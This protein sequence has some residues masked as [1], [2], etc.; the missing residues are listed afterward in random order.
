MPQWLLVQFS[1]HFL[2]SFKNEKEA[3]NV[4]AVVNG[5]FESSKFRVTNQLSLLKLFISI[6]FQ[7]TMG[8]RKNKTRKSSRPPK[9]KK[10]SSNQY[11]AGKV[12]E[13][14]VKDKVKKATVRLNVGAGYRKIVSL[15]QG[16]PQ[17]Q[18]VT[19]PSGSQ[20]NLVQF[21][22]SVFFLM[23]F[24]CLKDIINL[25]G[26]CPY[27]SHG[28]DIN[29]DTSEKL[30][31]SQQLLL[32][33]QSSYC[34][35]KA[36]KYSSPE[37]HRPSTPGRKFQTVNLR[38]VM[39]FREI[40]KGHQALQTFAS[41]MNMPRPMSHSNY[42]SINEVLHGAYETIAESSM[43]NTAKEVR[44][45]LNNDASDNDILDTQVSIDG[46]WQ[47]GGQSSMNGV[48]TA[49][50]SKGKVTDQLVMT[51]HCRACSIWEKKKGTQEYDE[52]LANH[53]CK[54]NHN[55]SSGA[56]ETVGAITFFQRLI[57]KYNLRYLKFKGDGDTEA[58]AKVVEAKPY[59]DMT[60]KKLECVGHVQKRLWTRLRALRK[61]L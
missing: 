40:G 32:N 11:K 54:I 45:A 13:A 31:F 14:K 38:M 1:D 15:A 41:C 27:C 21:Q 6:R 39:A 53:M 50:S 49:V 44:H 36:I 48:A 34:D 17:K 47:K 33:C 46:S 60:I 24:D 35:W 18:N 25:V 2:L 5:M 59:R 42:D 12:E 9:K 61:N 26:K 19:Q 37:L 57:E 22:D 29:I 4:A 58:F 56:M 7:W 43:A 20:D 52:W 55:K 3:K 23:N 28:I 16:Q 51:K 8:N 30:G 10:F